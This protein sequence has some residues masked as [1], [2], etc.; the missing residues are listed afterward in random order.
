MRIAI[1]IHLNVSGSY[2]RLDTFK[3]E[4]ITIKENVKDFRDVKKVFTSMSRTFTVPASKNNNIVL[5]HFYRND[6]VG[7]DTRALIDAKLTLN[8][9]DYKFGNVSVEDVKFKDNEPYSYSLRFYGNLT[10]LNKNIGDD[11]LTDLDLSSHNIQSPDFFDEFQKSTLSASQDRDVV[12]PL[13]SSFL[14][15]V[16]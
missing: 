2:F 6:I 1:D 7:V 9:V 13:L 5:K 8:N 12:F 16:Y 15:V 10:E 14:S 3:D 11:E 4:N